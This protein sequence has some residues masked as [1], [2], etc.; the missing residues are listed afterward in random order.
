MMCV[1]KWRMTD[2]STVKVLRG[3]WRVFGKRWGD[4]AVMECIAGGRVVGGAMTPF[5][6]GGASSKRSS[7]TVFGSSSIDTRLLAVSP[8]AVNEPRDEAILVFRRLLPLLLYRSRN[9]KQTVWLCNRKVDFSRA[10]RCARGEPSAVYRQSAEQPCHRLSRR[11][12]SP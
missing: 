10:Y 9:R 8:V 6:D 12:L 1:R 4:C 5:E 2:S 11:L 3:T 7:T